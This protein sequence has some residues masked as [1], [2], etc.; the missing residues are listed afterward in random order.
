MSI[1]GPRLRI[2]S[3]R[4]PSFPKINIPKP[5]ISVKAIGTLL[6]IILILSTIVFILNNPLIINNHINVTWE[7]NP[8][9]L[10]GS[11]SNSELILILT[12]NTKET[13]NID[14][15]VTTQSKEIIIFC[16][17]SNFP[18]VAQDHSRKT[19]CIIRRN[20]N[21]KIYS[22]TYQIN[23]QTNLGSTKTTLEIRK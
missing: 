6:I 19:T 21:E 23:I 12:N 8:L 10:S 17:D 11:T 16:P 5:Q 9:D 13:Q 15:S 18:N 1:Y 20:P 2:P 7:N 22:G 4:I 3:L 14:L